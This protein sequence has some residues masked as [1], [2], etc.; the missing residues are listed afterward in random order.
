[1]G[2][3]PSSYLDKVSRFLQQFIDLLIFIGKF[4]LANT[5]SA[6][7]SDLKANTYS[8]KGLLD[9]GVCTCVLMLLLSANMAREW[10]LPG[11]FLL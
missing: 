1:M 7:A 9:E 2:M 3:N 8:R 6:S 4:E 5:V 11:M 10:F